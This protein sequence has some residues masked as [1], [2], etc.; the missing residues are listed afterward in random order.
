[1]KLFEKGIEK[2]EKSEVKSNKEQRVNN[3]IEKFTIMLYE[4]VVRSLLEKD[5][6]L[7]SFLMT[8]KLM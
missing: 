5:K 3:I 2:A 7:F 8:T 1:M 6:L 4:H